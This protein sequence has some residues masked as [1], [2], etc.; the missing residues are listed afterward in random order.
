MFDGESP[1]FL[2]ELSKVALAG[3]YR[4]KEN[5]KFTSKFYNVYYHFTVNGTISAVLPDKDLVSE[6]ILRD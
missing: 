3:L 2:I 4:I 1:I 6:T 5:I